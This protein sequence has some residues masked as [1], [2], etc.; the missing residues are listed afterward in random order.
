MYLDNLLDYNPGLLKAAFELHHG[1][2]I[3]PNTWVIDLDAV[4]NNARSLSATASRLGLKTYLMSKQH[5]RNPYVNAVAMANGLGPI[6]AVDVQCALA[7]DRYK[8][9]LGHAGHLNQIPRHCLP[10]VLAMEPEVITVYCVEQAR[11]VSEVAASLSRV[12]PLLLRVY[13]EGDLQFPGIEG[14]FP[15]ETLAKAVREIQ[16]LR[17]VRVEGLTAFPVPR[18]NC[19]AETPLELSGNE[20]TLRAARELLESLGVEVRQMNMPGNTDSAMMELLAEAGATHV[21]PGNAL[22]GTTPS[23]AFRE[24]LPERTAFCY[25]TEVTHHYQGRAYAHGGGS[26]HNNYADRYWALVGNDWERSATN[27]ME[28]D[29]RIKQDIDY[30]MQLLPRSPKDA[31]VG[32]TVLFAHRT[33]MHMTRSWVA[34]ISGISKGEPWLHFLTDNAC[35]PRRPLDG[36]L[37]AV[38]AEEVRRDIDSLLRA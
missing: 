34:A 12:Q 17:G 38:S 6:V 29:P 10:L 33:Q 24:D 14:G 7:C 31:Q 5:N 4:A 22:L 30:H 25:V 20:R 9:A 37:A 23:N 18:Y 13:A 3:P 26:Y 16:D 36:G 35:N 15:L 32:D 2:R 19:D 8:I 21:E 11:A 28:Y 27:R 1:G